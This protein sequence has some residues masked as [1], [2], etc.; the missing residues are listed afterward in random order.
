MIYYV[1]FSFFMGC[2]FFLFFFGGG[3][4]VWEWGRRRMTEDLV[5][6]SPFFHFPHFLL[7]V[8]VISF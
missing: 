4:F 1:F 7:E 5:H 6:G 2:H 3:L 8:I